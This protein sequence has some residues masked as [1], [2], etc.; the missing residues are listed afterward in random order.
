MVRVSQVSCQS[1]SVNKEQEKIDKLRRIR[2]NNDINTGVRLPNLYVLFVSCLLI[3]NLR[4][5]SL[6]EHESV[7][8]V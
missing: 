6:I 2:L 7:R 3:I 5:H 8:F 4:S 1:R